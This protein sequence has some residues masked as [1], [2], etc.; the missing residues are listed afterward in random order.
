MVT[1]SVSSIVHSG[2]QPPFPG[3][4]SWIPVP[5]YFS[6]HR[7]DLVFQPAR[8]WVVSHISPLAGLSGTPRPLIYLSTCYVQYVITLLS[9]SLRWKDSNPQ[10]L[11]QNQSC[12]HLHHISMCATSVAHGFPNRRSEPQTSTVPSPSIHQS[13]PHPQTPSVNDPTCR[14]RK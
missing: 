1:A 10:K 7:G 9:I 3:L 4:R 5:R 14:W 6:P 11:D 8:D 13:R 12:C 2:Y